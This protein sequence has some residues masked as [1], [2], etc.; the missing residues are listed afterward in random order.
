VKKN[1]IIVWSFGIA[2]SV[3]STLSLA[4]EFAAPSAGKVSLC[5][6]L[7]G[8]DPELYMRN[9]SYTI[10]GTSSA[11]DFFR[12][13]AGQ[14]LYF[15]DLDVTQPGLVRILESGNSNFS[16]TFPL[17]PDTRAIDI[18]IHSPPGLNDCTINTFTT[19]HRCLPLSGTAQT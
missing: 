8:D 10:S 19:K 12:L 1:K 7:Q 4:Q 17:R 2:F 15:A 16:C 3:F 9:F 13:E 6:R 18:I 11:A 14:K 5:V